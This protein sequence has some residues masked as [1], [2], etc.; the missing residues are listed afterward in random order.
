MS[1][2]LLP[3]HVL[4]LSVLISLSSALLK[5]SSK[6]D[7]EK[8]LYMVDEAVAKISIALNKEARP[9]TSVRDFNDNYCT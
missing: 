7:C 4:L 1:S 9:F 2:L 8:R 6:P 5:P 3:I